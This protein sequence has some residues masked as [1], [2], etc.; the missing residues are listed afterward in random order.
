MAYLLTFLECFD[1]HH[2][3]TGT[4]NVARQLNE[5]TV[6]HDWINIVRQQVTAGGGPTPR[7]MLHQPIKAAVNQP[8]FLTDAQ[9]L[10]VKAIGSHTT[11]ANAEVKSIINK[12]RQVTPK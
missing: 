1:K 11:Q 9:A 5:K 6:Q 3:E 4:E 10:L 7:D 2:L 12:D 8:T